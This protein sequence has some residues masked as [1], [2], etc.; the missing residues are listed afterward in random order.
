MRGLIPAIGRT[1]LGLLLLMLLVAEGK[2]AENGPGAQPVER[3]VVRYHDG[4]FELVGRTTVQKVIAPTMT[5]AD[6][7]RNMSGSWFELQ[8][9]TGG[10]LYGRP[11]SPPNIAYVEHVA[12][13]TTGR[14]ERQEF[15]V[16]D[17]TFLIT[18]PQRS[19]G[20]RVAIYG[21]KTGS[22][23]KAAASQVLGY[24]QLR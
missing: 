6:T 24:I 17:R 11:L 1:A 21:N 2:S 15:T 7:S 18:V 14:I 4:T 8:T 19:D 16:S 3:L 10:M 20:A 12:D 5:L 9:S 23:D 22:A 13:S